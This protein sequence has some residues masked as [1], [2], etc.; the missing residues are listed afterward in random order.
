[1][2]FEFTQTDPAK[3]TFDET[4]PTAAPGFLRFINYMLDCIFLAVV[5]SV[6]LN[7]F[8][9]EM[10]PKSMEDVSSGMFISLLYPL[11]F[12]YYFVAEFFFGKTLAKLLTKTYVTTEFNEKPGVSAIFIR[13]LCRYIPFEYIS[14]LGNGIGWHDRLSKTYVVRN[15]K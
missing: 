4:M 10:M 3:N 11:Q 14:F 1:M 2:N 13:T 7:I 6:I 15:P 5:A 8:A 9:P 12:V